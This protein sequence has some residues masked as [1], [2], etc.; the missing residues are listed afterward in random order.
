[1]QWPTFHVFS[2]TPAPCNRSGTSRRHPA[3]QAI[4]SDDLASFVATMPLLLV[5][6]ATLSFSPLANTL[7]LRNLHPLGLQP[8]SHAFMAKTTRHH[9]AAPR[10]NLAVD[11][12]VS[13]AISFRL[14]AVAFII[15]VFVAL[16]ATKSASGIPQI[17]AM[18]R[19]KTPQQV[20]SKWGTRVF[21][22]DAIVYLS[23]VVYHLRRGF[24]V[25]CWSELIPLLLQ[26]LACF[27]LLRSAKRREGPEGMRRW[28]TAGLDAGFVAALGVI[29]V[30]LPA[31]YLPLLCL[32]SMPLSVS[33]YS[34]QVVETYRMGSSPSTK[35]AKS[36]LLRWIGSLVRVF[37]TARLLGGDWPAMASHAVGF[38]GCSLLLMQRYVVEMGGPTK[39]QTRRA[40]YTQLLG[41]AAPPTSRIPRTLDDTL[42]AWRSLGGAHKPNASRRPIDCISSSSPTVARS[43]AH[44]PRPAALL[45][46]HAFAS[47]VV[48][49]FPSWRLCSRR[50]HACPLALI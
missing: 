22:G 1:M 28:L 29:M 31:R 49:L 19:S 43:T 3:A 35:R 12:S 4:H 45:L 26:N 33:S 24:P 8:H 37:T 23:R 40:L 41:T 47:S 34:V 48:P 30:M 2:F 25:S 9:L 18:A 11:V 13:T 36:V 39:I 38:V 44:L 20:G 6:Y 27:A 21:Y 17:I 15:P 42:H 32:W 5:A 50:P 7:P 14:Q 10:M 16:F 46:C